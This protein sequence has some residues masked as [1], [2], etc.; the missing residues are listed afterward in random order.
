M[1]PAVPPLPTVTTIALF[2]ADREMQIT[3][4]TSLGEILYASPEIDCDAGTV[5]LVLL[6]TATAVDRLQGRAAASDV[7]A[8]GT[9]STLEAWQNG[10]ATGPRSG[11]KTEN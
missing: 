10:V 8:N 3:P 6:T 4:S 11:Y 9:A 5:S 7:T 2:P 1:S